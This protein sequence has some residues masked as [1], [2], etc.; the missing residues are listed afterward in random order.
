M[1]AYALKEDD[2]LTKEQILTR[3]A[4]VFR[5]L[6]EMAGE[7][8]IKIDKTVKPVQH[9]PRRTPVMMRDVGSGWNIV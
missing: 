2:K 3:Y 7:Y 4:E 6:S 5:G 9:G 8:V 1:V